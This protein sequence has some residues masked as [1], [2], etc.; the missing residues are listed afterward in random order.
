MQCLS[1]HQWQEIILK[2]VGK[3][4]ITQTAKTV[5][6]KKNKAGGILLPDFKLY[7]KATV[8]KTLWYCTKID[9]MKHHGEP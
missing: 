8:F 1:E 3:H 2:H 7:N 5:M 6:R 9:T 4:K